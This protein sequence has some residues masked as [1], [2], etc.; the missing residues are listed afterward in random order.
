MGKSFDIKYLISSGPLL[1]KA[2]PMTFYLMVLSLALA[3]ALAIPITAMRM[4]KK[5]VVRGIATIYVSFIRGTP[6]LVLLFLVYFGLP[7]LLGSIGIDMSRWTKA[8]FMIL[9]FCLNIAA[10]MSEILRAAYLSV[11]KGQHEAGMVV[12]MTAFQRFYRIILPQAFV[13]AL[14]NIGNTMIGL[15]KETSLAFTIGI[16]DLMGQVKNVG[17]RTYGAR[18]LE[19]YIAVAVIYWFVCFLL[20]KGLI[21]LENNLTIDKNSIAKGV[22]S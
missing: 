2:L 3:F 13:V 1:L 7:Q 4:R 8:S 5:G 10:Y 18:L 9:A 14:P 17:A 15:F 20:E 16:V 19:L 6:P 11:D 21:L 22:K 12:G